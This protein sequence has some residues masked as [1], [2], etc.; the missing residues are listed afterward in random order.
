MNMYTDTKIGSHGRELMLILKF[1]D[2]AFLKYAAINCRIHGP[3]A[4]ETGVAIAT[5]LC[6]TIWVVLMLTPKYDLDTTSQYRVIS[7]STG[8]LRDV[9]TLNFDILTLE[10]CHVMPLR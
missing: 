10:S 1:I 7:F 6:P 3:V 5:I 2:F 4:N 8:T 9:V